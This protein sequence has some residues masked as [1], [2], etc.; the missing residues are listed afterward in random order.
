MKTFVDDLVDG[1]HV[2]S[3]LN[4]KEIVEYARKFPGK[5]GL[6]A[7][8]TDP[9]TISVD[10]TKKTKQKLCPKKPAKRTHLTYCEE[11]YKAL[12]EIPNYKLEHLYYSVC[13][14]ELAHY[15]P[16]LSV[17]IW[18]FIESLTSI[19]DRHEKTDFHSYL[20]KIRIQSLNCEALSSVKSAREAIKRISEF[21]NTTKHDSVGAMF[22][23]EQLANDFELIAPIVLELAKEAKR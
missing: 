16:L 18:S 20:S 8:K 1:K 4:K 19:V 22:N 23:G 12:Q 3:R 6:S 11:I 14:L 9:V 7:K 5:A 13:K 15:T 2:N 10:P 21:G 17:G